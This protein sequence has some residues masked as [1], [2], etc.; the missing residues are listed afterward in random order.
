MGQF[1]VYGTGSQS[2]AFQPLQSKESLKL[3]NGSDPKATVEKK[4]MFPTVATGSIPTAPVTAPTERVADYYRFGKFAPGPDADYEVQPRTFTD[5]EEGN[6]TA[7]IRIFGQQPKDTAERDLI[8]AYTKF[9]LESVSEAHAERSQIVET[10][11]NF[12]VFMHGER[13]PMYTFSGKLVNSKNANWV[14]DFMFTYDT[15]LRGTRCTELNAKAILTYGGRQIE[16]LILSMQTGTQAS[17]EGSVE[18]SMQVV[19]FQRKYL[20]F[21]DDFGFATSDGKKLKSDEQFLKML[22]QVTGGPEGKGTS[23]PGTS[24]AITQ[25]TEFMLRGGPAAGVVQLR[26]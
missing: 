19:V 12:Y 26:K 11:G 17:L 14:Q 22:A 25:A 13:P 23:D 16:G 7:S 21:S 2:L 6:V 4:V 20:G 24:T 10:F 15:Y 1:D 18:F 5:F 9:F 8:P 3:A